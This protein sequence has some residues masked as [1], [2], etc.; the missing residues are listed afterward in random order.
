MENSAA[1]SR[2]GIPLMRGP[3]PLRGLGLGSGRFGS[4]PGERFK[5]LFSFQA[6]L[7]FVTFNTNFNLFLSSGGIC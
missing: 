7:A 1:L 3:V 6:I 2:G 4:F 5:Y